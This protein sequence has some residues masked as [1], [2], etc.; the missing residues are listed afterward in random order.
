MI[1][2]SKESRPVFSRVHCTAVLVAA[3]VLF[4]VLAFG[5][6][7]ALKSNSNDP[8]QWLPSGFD[9][10]RRYDWLQQHF[11]NDEITV[12]SWPGCTL[13]DERAEK[14]AQALTENAATAYFLRATT[15]GRVLAQLMAKP[16]DVPRDE[17]IERLK[18]TLIGPDG[19]TSCVVLTVSPRGVA[20]RAAALAELRRAAKRECDLDDDQLHLGG[21][22]VDAATIDIESQRMLL[23]LAG[24]SGLVAMAIAWIRLGSFR[25]TLILLAVAVYCTALSLAILYY[26]GGTMN[27]VMTMLP[28]LIFV[29]GISTS[30]H[31]VNYYR[32]ALAE[33]P[34]NAAPIMALR[35]GWRP[36]FLASFTTGLGLLSLAVSDIVPVKMFGI[37]AAAGTFAGLAVVLILLPVAL[38]VWPAKAP[39]AKSKKKRASATATPRIDRYFDRIR[40]RHATIVAGCILLMAVTGTGLLWLR[41]TVKLQYRF[42]AESRILQDYRWLE[43]HLGPLVPM[44]LVVHVDPTEHPSLADQLRQV[45]TLVRRAEQLSEVGAALSAADFA[46][47]LPR[48]TAARDVV[49]RVAWKRNAATIEQHLRHNHFF[50]SGDDGENLWRIS[51]RASALGDVDYGRFIDKL[52]EQ[53]EPAVASMRGVRVTYTGIIPLIYKAQRELLS[54][55]TESFLLA[56][57]LIAVVIMIVLRSIRCGLVAMIPNVFPVVVVFGLMGWLGIWIEIGSIMTASAAM[58]I[59]VDDTFHLLAWHSRALGKGA[60]RENAVH[61][62][63]RRCAGAMIHTTLVTA[64]ALLVF[65]FSSFM[66]IR[67]FAWMMATL[68]VAA[69]AG[70]LILLPAIL[71]GPIGKFFRPASRK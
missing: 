70:D 49:Q 47:T 42:G 29:L 9:E 26:T 59:A 2:R 27:L 37:Y 63:L 17:A 40:R 56:F 67:R 68:L 38:Q 20:N 30:I 15:A 36:C 31:L 4:P 10:T 11:G 41:S 44:E 28:P 34:A 6:V 13:F 8:R 55:L 7:G 19:R 62:A 50:A 69:L 64:C 48:G 23:S 60:N 54:D 45:V 16:L 5:L 65:S 33:G 52:R 22:T 21:P 61:A 14:L 58:G 25:L 43:E 32:D 39:A 24:L 18:G 3:V 71:V 46:P 57:A 12:V 51:V 35:H 53:V 1:G 66:P